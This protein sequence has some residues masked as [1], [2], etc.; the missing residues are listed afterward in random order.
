MRVP[1]AILQDVFLV[2]VFVLVIKAGLELDNSLIHS[3]T[4]FMFLCLLVGFIFVGPPRRKFFTAEFLSQFEKQHKE[5]FGE[6]SKLP[7]GEGYPDTGA[8]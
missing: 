8:G 4:V 1:G 5:A 6:N 3:I 7:V 2:W